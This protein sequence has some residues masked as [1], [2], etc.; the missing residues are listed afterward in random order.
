[1]KY[2]YSKLKGRIVEMFGTRTV[3][4]KKLEISEGALS[5]RLSGKMS[6]SQPEIEK[7]AEILNLTKEEIGL[8]FFTL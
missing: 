3:F 7:A 8:Y 1:M 2:D 4:A 6:F 5:L